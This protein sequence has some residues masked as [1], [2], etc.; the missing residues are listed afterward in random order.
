MNKLII[1]TTF[2]LFSSIRLLAAVG[3]DLNDPDRDVKR[4][5]QNSSGYKTVYVSIAQKGGDALLAKI[6]DR[7]GD[8]FKGLY[9]TKDIPYTIYEIYQ[10]KNI[11]GY[12]HGVNQK[13]VYGGIQVFLALD[14][15]G[16]IKGFYIQKLTSNTASLF[17][18][19]S[20]GNQF[21]GLSLK[22]FYGYNVAASKFNAEPSAPV[23]KNPDSSSEA[24]FK[25]IMRGVKKNLILMDEFMLNNKYIQYFKKGE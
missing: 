20:F 1:L 11:I 25:T 6:E 13:G 19:P 3:C 24:D 7:L 8:K 16:T 23:I 12:I 10:G 9:E 21:I 17:R 5:F 15:E 22:E 2:I 14:A 18:K 4:L